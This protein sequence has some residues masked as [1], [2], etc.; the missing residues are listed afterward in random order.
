MEI[1]KIKIEGFS[2]I[3]I[4]DLSIEK[5]NAL[6]ALNNYGKTNAINA[7]SFGIDFI[8]KSAKIKSNM[9]AYKPFIPINRH[10]ESKSFKFE[11]T[12]HEKWDGKLHTVVY[13]FAFDWIKNDKS[14]GQRIKEEYLKIKENKADAKFK[15]Y[16]SRNLKEALYM[17]SSTARCD[18]PLI[19]PKDEL[20][21]N[22]LKNYDELFYLDI[23][24]AINNISFVQ[25]DTLQ[26]PDSLFRKISP[27][28][29]K[30]EYSLE[31]PD[32]YNVSFFIFSLK[33]KKPNLY[34]LFKDSIRA[35]LPG[36]EE[37][38]PVEVDFKKEI[39]LSKSNLKLPLDFPEKIYDIIIK[40]KNNNQQT[41][42]NG[43]SSGSQKIFYVVAMTIAA[44]LNNVPL[45][46][47]EELE[48]SIHPGLLQKLLITLDG[49]ADKTKII[50]TSHS[51]YLIQYLAIDKIKI[52][53]PNDKDLAIFKE[54][55]KSK[56][57]SV[58][59]IAEETGTSIGDV[60]FDKMLECESGESVFL[61]ELCQQ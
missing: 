12:F 22:K 34:E 33:Q 41:K 6:I 21:I 9:M 56:F 18:T 19:I 2:N 44:D 24:N 39:K 10:I 45:I 55:K 53:I 52:G 35:L 25:I 5:I 36:I 20:S 38:E 37:F 30:N 27:E 48:N 43:L 47:F 16:L 29:I 23:V 51:P 46:S 3:E 28:V 42:I 14:K 57:K 15:T 7:I 49:L 31:M 58:I 59:N 61:N 50:L 13:G 4:L 8:K 26:D 40:E 17:R 54:I 32:D 11:V 1:L 60:I